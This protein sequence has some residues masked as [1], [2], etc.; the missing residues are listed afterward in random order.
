MLPS[1]L[2]LTLEATE[3]I[4]VTLDLGRSRTLPGVE[5]QLPQL[6]DLAR[7]HGR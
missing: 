5:P 2:G 3:A 6:G 7:P 4:V 1:L